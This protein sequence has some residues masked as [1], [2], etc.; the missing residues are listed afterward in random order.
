MNEKRLFEQL[1][2]IESKLGNQSERIAKLEVGQK[3][4]VTGSIL[5]IGA[6]ITFLFKLLGEIS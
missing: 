5:I 6:F 3:G 2:R 4:V 1:D